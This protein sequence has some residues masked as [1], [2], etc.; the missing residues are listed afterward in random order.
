MYAEIIR[1]AAA[2]QP[3]LRP[4]PPATDAQIHQAERLLHVQFP[5]ELRAFLREMNGDGDLCLSAEQIVE[6]NLLLRRDLV[7]C[8]DGL[9]QLL[10]IAQNGCGDH[11]GY[12]IA[13]GVISNKTLLF[14]EHETNE[15]RPAA[16]SFAE[17]IERFYTDPL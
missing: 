2:N 12:R 13:N 14:W 17:L 1:R 9:D 6:C 11:F 4:Q 10:F 3:Y 16:A 15:T 5:A 8:Y 7:E